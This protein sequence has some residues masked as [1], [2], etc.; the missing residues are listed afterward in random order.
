M[1][2]FY[3]VPAAS[4][5]TPSITIDDYY[6]TIYRICEDI[7]ALMPDDCESEHDKGYM[8]GLRDAFGKVYPLLKTGKDC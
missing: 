4:N 8:D 7:A 3:A 5:P 6:Q 2:V 1:K